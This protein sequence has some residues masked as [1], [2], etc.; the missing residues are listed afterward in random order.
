MIYLADHVIDVTRKTQE[1][2]SPRHQFIKRNL[3]LI[4]AVIVCISVVIGWQVLHPFSSLLFTV[5]CILAVMVAIHL[6][7]VQLNPTKQSWYN[8]K[9]LAIALIYGAGIYAAPVVLLHQQESSVFLPISC[10][11]L[12]AVIAF[13]NLLMASIIELKWDE[14]MDNTSLVRVMGQKQSTMLFYCLMG[15]SSLG[16]VVMLW[17]SPSEYNTMLITYL[18]MILGHL[19]IYKKRG[20]LMEYLAY[21]KLSEALFWLPIIA[22]FLFFK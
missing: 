18:L 17:H 13:I 4:I 2:P 19:L 21:R 8:N 14:E 1:Y 11:A 7:I 9:E 15:L 22:F 16:I 20:L 12:L 5:G 6:L 3:Q 10:A